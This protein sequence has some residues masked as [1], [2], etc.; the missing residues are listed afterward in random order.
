MYYILAPWARA[1][2]PLTGPGW[3]APAPSWFNLDLRPVG[4]ATGYGVFGLRDPQPFLSQHHLGDSLYEPLGT[5]Q[6]HD[7]ATTLGLPAGALDSAPTLLAAIWRLYTDLA[8]VMGRNPISP[9]KNGNLRLVLN[10]HQRQGVRMEQF[11]KDAHPFVLEYI[12]R[13]Y[14][15][16]YT[17]ALAAQAAY[18]AAGL[19]PKQAHGQLRTFDGDP[20]KYRDPQWQF[21]RSL[22]S[23]HLPGHHQRM[24]YTWRHNYGFSVE[25]MIP[26][27]L[28]RVDAIP[29]ATIFTDNFGTSA[30]ADLDAPWVEVANT[31]EITLNSG[32]GEAHATQG[33][34]S[35]AR[36]E[37]AVG[38]GDMY[39]K[40][41]VRLV[42]STA[43]NGPLARY[44]RA[45]DTCYHAG[46]RGAGSGARQD[47]IRWSTGSFNRLTS[48]DNALSLPHTVKVQVDTDDVVEHYVDDMDTPVLSQSDTNIP[49]TND[50]GGLAGYGGTSSRGMFDDFEMDLVSPAAPD[51][52]HHRL[53]FGAGYSKQG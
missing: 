48:S 24:L 3:D 21:L 29:H 33:A 32:D 41:E 17:R 19:T 28:P 50:D 6:R 5:T 36:A 1:D 35:R 23:L 20:D 4:Q 44:V 42:G 12:Q 47:L 34:A 13:K 16:V 2:S 31:W 45:A 7:I 27:D 14:R 22:K 46:L 37:Q 8:P 15:A 26:E 30:Q 49:D 25:E 51:A 39:A 11:D 18:T 43:P 53:G 38:G 40:C 9:G 10:G 52:N